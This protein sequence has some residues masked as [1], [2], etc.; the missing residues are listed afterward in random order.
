MTTQFTDAQKAA[1]HLLEGFQKLAQFNLEFMQ[2]SVADFA[3]AS[4]AMM[5]AKSPQEFSTLCAAELK[6]AQERA[7]LYGQRV[8]DI[9]KISGKV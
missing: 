3:K 1:A 2:S 9:L 4:Q 8:Q 7:T 6:A 5:S